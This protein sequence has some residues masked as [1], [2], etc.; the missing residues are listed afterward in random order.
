[1]WVK[2]LFG[3]RQ[4]A[5]EIFVSSQPRGAHIPITMWPETYTVAEIKI[6]RHMARQA[7]QDSL[8]PLATVLA[9]KDFSVYA[10]ETIIMCLL[11][12]VPVW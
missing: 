9:P 2:V 6:F 12:T 1:M 8:Q 3:V 4:G 10:V 7:P 5:S 11:N